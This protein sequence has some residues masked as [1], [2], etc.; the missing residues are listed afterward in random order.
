MEN[1]KQ[2]KETNRTIVSENDLI[3]LNSYILRHIPVFDSFVGELSFPIQQ[4]N[5]QQVRKSAADSMF[6]RLL[7]RGWQLNGPT[8]YS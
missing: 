4:M 6:L 5:V 3:G 2:F 8:G 1:R 7:D